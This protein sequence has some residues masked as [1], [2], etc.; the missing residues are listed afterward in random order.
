[1]KHEAIPVFLA[2]DDNY[3]PFVL[4]TILS[5]MDHT[6]EFCDFY[7]LDGGISTEK[8]TAI[9]ET[10]NILQKASVTFIP[11]DKMV[12][13]YNFLTVGHV[14]LPTYYRFFIADMFL[15]LEKAIYLDVDII[16]LEDIKE[17]YDTD[18]KEYVIGAICDQ[19]AAETLDDFKSN[20]EISTD[21]VYFNAGVLLMDL[22]LWREKQITTRLLEIEKVYRN[23]ITKNDQDILNKCFDKDYMELDIKFNAM[24]KYDFPILIRHYASMPKPWEIRPELCNGEFDDY[25]IFWD[26]KK[27][28]QIEH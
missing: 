25:H 5:I 12:S 3:A 4:T 9:I 21:S 24:K 6:K 15:E 16:F 23:R 22:A 19:A 2:A 28:F 18:L 7:V 14:T 10:L 20:I 11:M 8:K 27:Q 17:L 1:M 26:R 13:E